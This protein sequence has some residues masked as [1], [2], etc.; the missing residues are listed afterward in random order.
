MRGPRASASLAFQPKGVWSIR[1]PVA[2]AGAPFGVPDALVY[3]RTCRLF[4]GRRCREVWS[5]WGPVALFGLPLAAPQ[6]RHVYQSPGVER[7]ARAAAP[8]CARVRAWGKGGGLPKV[9][10]HT[11]VAGSSKLTAQ[12]V[13]LWVRGSRPRTRRLVLVG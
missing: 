8:F 12:G 5:I 3:T 7:Q 4:G 13:W 1:G 2:C 10:S 9:V 6:P 11:P